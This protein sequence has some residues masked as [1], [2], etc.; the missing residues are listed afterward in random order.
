MSVSLFQACLR[1][2][3]LVAAAT[4]LVGLCAI[5]PSVPAPAVVTVYDRGVTPVDAARTNEPR[6]VVLDP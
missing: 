1:V 5:A 4:M 3:L 2:F 6:V